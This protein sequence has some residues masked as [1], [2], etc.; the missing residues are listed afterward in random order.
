M[1]LY[2]MYKFKYAKQHSAEPCFLNPLF[3][4]AQ[5]R[6]KMA[7]EALER[8]GMFFDDLNRI[9]VLDEETSSQVTKPN[10]HKKKT[11][12]KGIFAQDVLVWDFQIFGE[13]KN[14]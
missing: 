1:L 5:H 11:M 14:Y 8:S 6:E 10:F 13:S 4:V 3:S 9:R 12:V 2:K 7:N